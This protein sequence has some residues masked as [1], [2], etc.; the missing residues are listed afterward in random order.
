MQMQMQQHQMMSPTSNFPQQHQQNVWPSQEAN[1]GGWP[2]QQQE[3]PQN[4]NGFGGPPSSFGAWNKQS[5]QS[6]QNGSN[7]ATGGYNNSLKRS[8]DSNLP[9]FGASNLPEKHSRNSE[10]EPYANR[11]AASNDSGP[12][13][14][15]GKIVSKPIPAGAP[16]KHLVLCENI[17]AGLTNQNIQKRIFLFFG[18]KSHLLFFCSY[19][20]FVKKGPF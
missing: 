3:S 13:I 5:N 14:A 18:D 11:L 12:N 8:A 4:S 7:N 2:M 10:G 17:P 9:G 1:N 16:S 6:L 15:N 20:F 19:F